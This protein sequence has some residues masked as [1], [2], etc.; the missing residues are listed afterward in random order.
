ME[1]SRF[2]WLGRVLATAITGGYMTDGKSGNP[3]FEDAKRIAMDDLESAMIEDA[4]EAQ[5]RKKLAEGPKAG[6]FEK[7]MGSM[8]GLQ[9]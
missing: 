1:Q 6:S 4:M 3:A 9:K 5:K 2:S 7:F 8:R